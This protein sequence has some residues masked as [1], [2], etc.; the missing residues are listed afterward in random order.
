MMVIMRPFLVTSC[1][2]EIL[3]VWQTGS[4]IDFSSINGKNA[5]D[6]NFSLFVPF[7]AEFSGAWP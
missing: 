6:E 1:L 7:R 4:G 3:L 2:A 5:D